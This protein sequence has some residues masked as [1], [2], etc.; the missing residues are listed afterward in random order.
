MVLELQSRKCDGPLESDIL[1]LSR[2]VLWPCRPTEIASDYSANCLVR[3]MIDR[4]TT[5]C[6][7]KEIFLIL[8]LARF[9]EAA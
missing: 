8:A 6:R 2:T 4:L 7:F 1:L 5:E 9:H 3:Y